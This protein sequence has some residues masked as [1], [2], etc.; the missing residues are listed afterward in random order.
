MR[1]GSFGEADALVALHVALERGGPRFTIEQ[2]QRVLAAIR[3]AYDA[4][5]ESIS[6]AVVDPDDEHEGDFQR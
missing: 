2:V 4:G 6:R 5:A 3:A 1:P